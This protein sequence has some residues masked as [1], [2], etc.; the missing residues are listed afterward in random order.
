ML[1]G[2]LDT[3][4]GSGVERRLARTGFGHRLK[5]DLKQEGKNK[6][7]KAVKEDATFI[8]SSLTSSLRRRKG[9]MRVEFVP[10][11]KRKF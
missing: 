1:D 11:R 5:T 3:I 8:I 9:G 7:S 4:P 2:L 10:L 6:W